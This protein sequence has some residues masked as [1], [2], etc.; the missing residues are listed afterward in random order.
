VTLVVAACG[1]SSGPSSNG[2][3]TKSPDGIVTAATSAVGSA[4]SVHVAGNVMNGGSRITL[5]LSLVNGRGGR[6]SM[7]ENGL[8]FQVVAVGD[9]VYI[10]GTI[11]FWEK[12][13]GDSAAQ[14]LWGKWIKA[15]AGG[16]LASL[17]TLTDL[18]KLF[19]QML[20]SHGRLAKGSIATVHGQRVITVKDIT[21]GGTMY[22][23]TTGEAYPIEVVENGSNGGRI[24]FD[25]FNQPVTLT[26]PSNAIDISQLQ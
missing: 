23:A 24:V 22:V 2:V 18:Q 15:P 14:L 13:A 10:N 9:E 19:R 25:R 7:A 21:N 12:F 8:S 26:A 16:D 20:S 5:D 4:R 11:A 6:G 3:E 17:A 1:G